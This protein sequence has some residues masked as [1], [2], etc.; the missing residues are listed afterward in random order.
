[1]AYNCLK[2]ENKLQNN[3]FKNVFKFIVFI[4][5]EWNYF[6]GGVKNASRSFFE[7]F[8]LGIMTNRLNIFITIFVVFSFSV[9]MNVMKI[10]TV[11]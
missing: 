11:F 7:K 9:V 1:M 8:Q 5:S 4:I 10:P 2:L 3:I 6:H